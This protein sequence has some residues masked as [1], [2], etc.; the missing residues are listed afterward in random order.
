[1][2]QKIW[3]FF[4]SLKLTLILF[5]LLASS[6]LIGSFIIQRPI[7]QEGQLE[8]AYSPETFWWFEKLGFF[9]LYHSAWFVLFIFLLAVNLICCTINMWPRHLKLYRHID[10]VH[11]DLTLLNLPFHDEWRFDRKSFSE[12]DLQQKIS[13]VLK[14][15]FK[16]PQIDVENGVLHFFVNRMRLAH[17]GVYVVHTGLLIIFSGGVWGSLDGFEGQMALFEGESSS[18]VILKN[19]LQ[20]VKQLPFT[21]KCHDIRKIDYPNGAPKEYF[22]DLEVLDA[23][24]RSVMR[25]TIEVNVPLDYGGIQFYQA[26]YK[27]VKD[28]IKAEFRLKI[29]NRKTGKSETVVLPDDGLNQDIKLPGS[30][31]VFRVLYYNDKESIP[32]GDGEFSVHEVI[33]LLLVDGKHH[34]VVTALVMPGFAEVDEKVRPDALETIEFLGR[35]ES[36]TL[37][38]V[39]GLQV[40][41]DPGAKIV[42]LGCTVVVIGILW[43]FFTR[44]EKIWVNLR[45]DRMII[46]GRA[47]RNP[48]VFRAQFEKMVAEMRRMIG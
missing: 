30:S 29:T 34:E 5:C 28:G 26:D 39:T 24:G 25:Q 10:P 20:H 1:M 8:R 47:S 45:E 14:R 38:E 41:R 21:I 40:A 3:K 15:F 31:R 32:L 36:F 18:R 48:W 2:T 17:F 9:D 27:T 35:K 4:C 7:A 6:V 22:S 23:Q 43:A 46:G 11:P 19:Q 13:G 33:R 44:H 12:N 16:S 37:R 42:F